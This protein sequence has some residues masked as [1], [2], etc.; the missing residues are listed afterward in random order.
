ML[1]DSAS[2]APRRS[3]GERRTQLV[4][5]AV[6]A[7]AQTGLHGTA[8]STVTDRVGVTQPYAFSLFRTKKGLFLAAIE[9]CFDHLDA[10]FRAAAA[11]KQGDEALQAL[12]DAYHALLQD[13]DWLL[14]Q[15]HA[16]AACGDDE[17]RE[18]VRRRYAA[19]YELVREL[20]GAPD[21]VLHDFFAQG[22]LM[23]VAAALDLPQLAER[24]EGWLE[25]CRPVTPSEDPSSQG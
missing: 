16:Y 4:E 19:L 22:M 1:A 7:F 23:N 3:A 18:L 9:H 8:V 14:L 24:D 20:S 17:V 25:W 2:P 5:A 13:R 11:G 12:G 6:G 21:M 15:L 10:T